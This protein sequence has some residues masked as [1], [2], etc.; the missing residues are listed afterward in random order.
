MALSRERDSREALADGSPYLYRLKCNRSQPCENCVRRGDAT[1]CHYAAPGS[2]KKGNAAGAS[3]SSPDDMQNRID[4]LEGL[5]LSLMTN[6]NESAGAAA[7]SRALSMSTKSD[8][9]DF[10]LSHQSSR[11]DGDDDEMVKDGGDG[12]SETEEVAKSLGVLKVMDNKSM[13]IGETHWAAI[14]NDISEV[15][16]YW[17]EHKKQ[18]DDQFN[19]VQ[20][21]K[22]SNGFAQGPAF[23]F[24]GRSVPSHAELL[25]AVPRR[26]AMDKIVARYFN[27]YDPTIHI[28][29]P[30]SWRRQYEEYWKDPSKTSVVWLGQLFAIASLTMDSYHRDGDEPFEYQGRTLKLAADY[31]A[32]TAQCLLRADFTRPINHMIETL[33]LHLYCEYSRTR[34]AEVGVWV[35]IGIVVR[36]AMRM[37]YHRDPKY[38]PNLTPFQGEM[39]RRSW[40]FVR[41]ADCLFS[42]QMG[43]PSM[44]RLGDTDTEFPRN[45]YD[46]EFDEQS[47][48]L[49]ASRPPNSPTPVSFMIAKARISFA[50]GSIVERL[51]AIKPPQY[52]EIIALDQELRQS[53]HEAPPHLKP[54]SMDV[55]SLDPVASIMQRFNL[56]VL[57][58]KGQ[59]V[60]HRKYLSR[61]REN[62]RYEA[63]RRTC[64]D[65]SMELLRI[66][67]T[68]HSESRPGRRLHCMKWY[69]SS[70]TSHDFLLAATLVCLDL[71]YS[72]RAEILGRD[73]YESFH[74]SEEQRSEMM[75]ALE[76][77]QDIWN[78][79]RDQSMEA[80]KASRIL[81]VMIQTINNMRAHAASLRQSNSYGGPGGFMGS[82]DSQGQSLQSQP[83]Q[84]QS[85]PMN[86][87]KAPIT[88]SPNTPGSAFGQNEFGEKPE[89]SAALTLGLLSSGGLTPNTMSMFAGESGSG[90]AVPGGFPMTPGPGGAGND[91]QPPLRGMTPNFQLDP[92]LMGYTSAP[93]PFSL[94]TKANNGLDMNTANLDWDA[95]DS[96]V[97]SASL[98]VGNE[99]WPAGMDAPFG[100]TEM[101]K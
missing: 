79:L 48:E 36:L 94:L 60:L 23:I 62:S 65:S 88:Q 66:Q 22:K 61:A 14:L 42:F 16:N 9:P 93:S 24:G 25:K 5:V 38:Y 43:L 4:R 13:Y 44:L 64:V 89:H 97:Q 80:F 84:S 92:S 91:V 70:L 77:S 83:Q 30:P 29:H 45:I 31:R 21:I 37:G 33:I 53:F 68:L 28:L 74:W 11:D 47:V 20:E 98:E 87:V 52:E 59:C 56:S 54:R 19:R 76:I 75:H 18:Y 100:G 99:L 8:S 39:R 71:W 101:P 57:Y 35:M 41:Q 96:Y 1:A 32:L 6:G 7:A 55:S 17:A 3:P 46:E 34:E 90:A 72:A 2:R 49:P 12:E 78:E 85:S 27:D 95:W 82:P 10:S 67:V 15:R 69:I 26:E 86:G 40:T 58:H 63:S 50:F 51:H 73:P 81:E